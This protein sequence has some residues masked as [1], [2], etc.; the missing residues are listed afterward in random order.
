MT[1]PHVLPHV[2]GHCL[3]LV[4]FCV[5]CANPPTAGESARGRPPAPVQPAVATAAVAIDPDDPAVWVQPTDPEKSLI[6]GT[7]K[8][9]QTG[10]LHV[11]GL[12][13]KIRQ[14]IAPLDR[15]NNVDV[16]YDFR[17]AGR[18]LDIAVVTERLRHRL[19]VYGI[20]ADGSDL[21]DIAPNGVPVLAGQIGEAAEPMG[22]ALYRRPADGAV[23]AI[24]A[25][26]T[27]AATDYL[28]QYRLEDVHGE[29]GGRL[30]RRFGNFSR[31]GPAPGEIGEIEAVVVDDAL[32]YV[33]YSDERFGIR[34]WHADPDH[35]DA[36]REL[37]VF[38]TAGYLGDREG[39]A[40]Y[41]KPDG[42][43]FLVSSDQVAG[44][45]RL[46]IYK[47]EGELGRSDHHPLVAAV[48]T[49]S[50]ETD[51]LEVTSQP[52]P[53]FPDGL[54]VMMNSASKNFLIYGWRAVAARFGP[55]QPVATQTR[56]VRQE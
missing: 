37:A 47:R 17:M 36:A 44:G 4:F 54:V 56:L 55:E 26:K 24:V 50:D 3:T 21:F 6:L 18:R 38:A 1:L 39:L 33:Y 12:D 7:D 8:V 23:F 48:P 10:G 9:A 27:G 49:R 52:L 43:G 19:R 5:S 11:F 32:G 29:V 22:I 51:G 35:P 15:P 46:M 31:R 34:K 13:G 28:W 20:P 41:V 30:V 25:P 14:T 16:E 2:S 42:T 40:V 45:S 53:G